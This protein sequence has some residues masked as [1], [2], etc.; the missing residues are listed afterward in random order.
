MLSITPERR[1][2]IN[3]MRVLT[4]RSFAP[5]FNP[6]LIPAIEYRIPFI[7]INNTAAREAI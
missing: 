2:I 5:V 3:P 1:R 7:T 4:I 6:S